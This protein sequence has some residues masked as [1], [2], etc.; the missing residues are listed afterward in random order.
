MNKVITWVR[1][2]VV[3]VIFCV[4]MIAALVALPIVSSKLNAGIQKDMQ[5][6]IQ[7]KR[8]MEG[9]MR[10][11]VSI[12]SQGLAAP[13]SGTGIVND[14]FV[15]EY[16]AFVGM[17]Q[18]DA[19]A[20]LAA[21]DDHNR[22]SR[23][24]LHNDFPNPIPSKL[25]VL[26][27]Q[28]HNQVDQAYDRLLESVG[29]G[30]APDPSE[31]AETI[32]TR[33]AQF[34]AS[35]LQ[36][37]EGD[38]LNPEEVD[39]LREFLIDARLG[40][41]LDRADELSFY[42]TRGAVGVPMWEQ[43]R[44]YSLRDL[45]YWQWDYWVTEDIL[46][47]IASAN[48]GAETLRAAPVKQLEFIEIGPRLTGA[49]GG[50]NQG[51]GGMSPG[52]GPGAGPGGGN[53]A[54]APPAAPAD[55]KMPIPQNFGVSI[56]GRSSNSLYDVRP[57]RVS[58]VVDTVR[59]PEVLDAFAKQ[60]LM[61]VTNLVVTEVDAFDAV[62]QGYYFGNDSVSRLD[63]DIETIWL[64]TWTAQFMPDMVK[65]E[66]GVPIAQDPSAGGDVPPMP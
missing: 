35:K 55:P 61:T 11:S 13:I 37:D 2:N 59:I 40:L 23:G 63:L 15:R 41:Y 45:Y 1:A 6:K 27:A 14:A 50:G 43:T 32:A 57:V 3:I 30:G 33:K 47:A 56:T 10:T 19:D 8:E 26:P 12:N 31:I 62:Q 28:F 18:G 17:E 64:R 36:K 49:G 51:G 66:L 34:L 52:A 60:N 21:A 42:A 38:D 7:Q 39:K 44:Q 48:E 9:L 20:L 58:L 16:E 53:Q 24:V 65:Q 54:A 22:K 29:A 25:E 5:A 4:V 46:R